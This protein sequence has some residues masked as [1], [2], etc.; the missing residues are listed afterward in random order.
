MLKPL[1]LALGVMNIILAG[2]S[3]AEVDELVKVRGDHYTGML[4]VSALIDG[5]ALHEQMGDN[6]PFDWMPRADSESTEQFAAGNCHVLVRRL[7]PSQAEK[8][9]FEDMFPP[10][11]PQPEVFVVGYLRVAVVVHKGNPITGLSLDQILGLL[12]CRGVGM[13]W[14]DLGGTGAA[15][16]C[17]VGVHNGPSEWVVR[18][19][20][21]M[22]GPKHPTGYYRLREDLEQCKSEEEVLRRV[23]MDRNGIG[24]LLY[25]GQSLKSVRVLAIKPSEQTDAV[26]LKEDPCAQEHYPLQ[27]PVLLYLHPKAPLVAKRF[28]E[29]AVSK[30]GAQIAAERGLLTPAAAFEFQ[31]QK[32]SVQVKARKGERISVVGGGKGLQRL[33]KLLSVEY[34]RAKAV[35]RVAY[36]SPASDVAAVGAFL[37]MRGTGEAARPRKELLLL[38]DRPDERAM[39]VHGAKWSEL[40]PTEYLIAGRGVAVVVNPANKL[41]ALTLEQVRTIFSGELND[42]AVLG[43]TGLTA[44]GSTGLGGGKAAVAIHAY[45]LPVADGAA[46]LFRRECL[47]SGRFGRL[48]VKKDSAQVLQAVATDPSGIGLVDLSALGPVGAMGTTAGDSSVKVLALVAGAQMTWPSADNLKNAMYPLSQRVYLYVHPQASDAAKDFAAFVASCGS[49]V[50]TP[51]VDAVPA[52]MAA[53]RSQ[54]LIPLAEAAIQRAAKEALEAATSGKGKE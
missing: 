21:M 22:L 41:T 13:R 24:F 48:T 9:V 4:A 39:Q 32:R 30:E 16:T 25:R 40:S 1:M 2:T 7:F 26:V 53:Y 52:T 20:C 38:S 18:H 14:G 15:V 36:A 43:S 11:G 19:V 35:V 51:Y 49:S 3:S 17:Y 10:D 37:A 31:S 28:C 46:Q 44:G 47:A 12:R 6:K 27:E 50:S 23:Q 54:G 5:F 34:V 42:W 29:F 45:G 8:S 33:S